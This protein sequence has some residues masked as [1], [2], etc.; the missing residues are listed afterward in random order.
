MDELLKQIEK[1]D[2]QQLKKLAHCVAERQA[3]IEP[4]Y[5]IRG[6]DL[7]CPTKD[8]EAIAKYIKE[9]FN[10]GE[11]TER[12]LIE[13]ST[14]IPCPARSVAYYVTYF[15]DGLHRNVIWLDEDSLQVIDMKEVSFVPG[16]LDDS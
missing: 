13:S 3:K 4:L 8:L 7:A 14:A 16:Q 11:V 1:C 5:I 6:T 9:E 10:E 15:C 2:P 12:L